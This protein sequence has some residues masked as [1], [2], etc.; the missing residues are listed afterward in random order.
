MRSELGSMVVEH[1]L[2]LSCGFRSQLID[3]RTATSDVIHREAEENVNY[4]Q[5]N[6]RL[7]LDI[8]ATL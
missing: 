7:A 4:F 2:I 6:L 8:S 5:V 3:N 1:Y